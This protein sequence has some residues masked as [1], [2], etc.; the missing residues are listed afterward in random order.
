MTFVDRIR[1]RCLL[2]PHEPALVLPAP[3]SEVVTYARLERSLNNA[4]RALNAIGIVP[5]TVYGLLVGDPLL[6]LA[7]SLALEELGAGSMT[8]YDLNL[9]K[10]WPFTA[11]LSNRQVAESAWPVVP[12][13]PTWLQGDAPAPPMRGVGRSPDDISR[14]IL[15]SGSTGIPKGVAFTHRAWE[16]RLAHFDYIY[17]QLALM[18]RMMCLV[19][20]AEHRYCL[21]SLA[22]G[23]LYCF[24]DPS[25][26]STAR[27][28]ATY[29]VQYLAAAASTLGN[30]L[31]GMHP[32]RKGF[33]SLE[34]IRAGGSH[35]PRK[36]A[37]RVRDTMCSRL[38]TSYGSAET[39]TVAAGW[40]ETLDLD[41][42]EVGFLIPGAH[43]DFVDENTREPVTKGSG[44]LRIKNLGLASGYFGGTGAQEAFV[45]NAFYSND[46]GSLGA[47]GRLS[48]HGRSSNVINL[49]GDKATIERIELHYAKAPGIR[50][51]AV[52]P[53][54][55][56]LDVTKIVAVIAPNDQWSEQKAWEH[57]RRNLP[58]NYWPVK[59][60]VVENLPRGANGKVDRARLETVIAG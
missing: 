11:I 35:L 46:I 47:G 15:T 40:A 56:S 31:S 7:L 50:E 57:F 59:L 1:W 27:K 34:L 55:N 30:I 6:H 2:H 13:D 32:D 45:D 16:Q 52:V 9:P 43:I 41:N 33:Q 8:L 36:L 28:I 20:S 18:K 24:A 14:V 58:R 22:R 26:E 38:I 39:G 37:Q 29:K 21:Y 4:S 3:A 49:G 48:I 42:G 60:V 23:G 12:V 53:V 51:L 10:Q 54:R 17:G 44:A 25:I 19:V 5:G